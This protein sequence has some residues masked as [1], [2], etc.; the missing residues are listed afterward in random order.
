VRK[1]RGRF[2][3]ASSKR[4]YNY[5][6]GFNV[7]TL[8]GPFIYLL[9]SLRLDRNINYIPAL[10]L[11]SCRLS[12]IL[13]LIFNLLKSFSDIFDIKKPE[14]SLSGSDIPRNVLHVL[15]LPPYR[16]IEASFAPWNR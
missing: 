15:S 6:G 16:L 5:A 14:G 12:S 13:L 7:I 9:E 10:S 11:R 1:R 2:A 4:R 3:L 8:S